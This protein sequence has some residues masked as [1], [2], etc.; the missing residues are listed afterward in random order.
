M[1]IA[2][3]RSLI[4]SYLVVIRPISPSHA[5]NERHLDTVRHFFHGQCLRKIQLAQNHHSGGHQPFG[6]TAEWKNTWLLMARAHG[7]N[8]QLLLAF[9]RSSLWWPYSTK[10]TLAQG[11]LQC[12]VPTSLPPGIKASIFTS[13]VNRIWHKLPG[14]GHVESAAAGATSS[15]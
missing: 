15:C 12:A 10:I 7:S 2:N 11:C 3:L 4:S 9:H 5:L 8:W 13:Q 6:P 14:S 1:P